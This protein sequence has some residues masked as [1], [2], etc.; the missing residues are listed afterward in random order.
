M[1]PRRDARS[2]EIETDLARQAGGALGWSVL[3]AFV[4]KFG[5]LAIGIAL[6]RLLGPEAFGTY[7]VAM[8]ALLA[9]LS[10]NELGVS[11]AIVR[12]RGDPQSIVPTV[13]T[14]S[15]AMSAALFVA[16]FLVTPTYAAAMGDPGATGVVRLMLV[17]LLVNGLV[18]S[19]AALMQ[20]KFRQKERMLVDQTNVWV[21]AVLSLVLAVVGL[22]AMSLAIGRVAGSVLSAVLFIRFEPTGVRFGLDRSLLRPLLRFGI[23]LAGSSMTVFAAGYAD[24]VVAGSVLGPAQLGYYVLAFNLASWPVTMFSQP[25]RAVAPAAFSRLQHDHVALGS[26]MRWVVGALAAVTFPLCLLLSGAAGPVIRVVYGQQWAPAAAPL[27][28]LGAFAA[29]RITFEL[30]YDYLVVLRRSRGIFSVQVVWLAVL[31]PALTLGAYTWGIV[32]VAGAQVAIAL[33]VVLPLYLVQLARTGLEPRRVL[34]RLMLPVLGGATV[35]TGAVVAARTVESDV[36]ACVWAGVLAL[37][38]V[39]LL[40]VRDRTFVARLRALRGSSGQLP[41]EV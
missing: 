26:S 40:I 6:A 14:I 29:L 1:T 5:T 4:S 23:P 41:V 36:L 9:M 20:R 24:Q 22:G 32:G 18:A 19:P 17:G 30:V 15:V 35:W 16:A 27:A 13:T 2:P 37:T 7:A 38:V 31:V 34:G 25:V 28:W 8:V 3:N 21:G 33:L 10:F 11:L 39:V 12:W